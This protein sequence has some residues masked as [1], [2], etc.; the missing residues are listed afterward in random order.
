MVSDNIDDWCHN[1]IQIVTLAYAVVENNPEAKENAGTTTVRT[2]L[3]V[4]IVEKTIWRGF[5]W[6]KLRM[7]FRG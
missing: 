6:A 7:L 3:N 5:M 2:D 1:N 4:K